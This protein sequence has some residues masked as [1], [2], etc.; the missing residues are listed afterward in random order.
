MAAINVMA[1]IIFKDKLRLT[2]QTFDELTLLLANSN[3][4]TNS[5]EMLEICK[6]RNFLADILKLDRQLKKA[7]SELASDRKIFA[8]PGEDPEIKE[9]AIAEIEE[10]ETQITLL[11]NQIYILLLPRDSYDERNIF[12]EII[13]DNDLNKSGFSVNDL[14]RMYGLYSETQNWKVKFVSESVDDSGDL[15]EVI[16]AIEG[17]G[18]YG[19]LK[20]ETGVHQLEAVETN[21]TDFLAIVKV[22]PQLGIEEVEIEPQEI[23]IYDRRSTNCRCHLCVCKTE[24]GIQILHQPTGIRITCAEERSQLQNRERAMKILRA[25]LY[26]STL[27]KQ[28]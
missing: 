13:A 6:T 15:K 22:M 17:D 20:S 23:K 18:V 1:E 5:R 14:A 19:K 21:S 12:L 2:K 27:A 28:L 10:L 11:T 3:L 16:L 26:E 8:N 4:D 7:E 25:T 24:F 9:L